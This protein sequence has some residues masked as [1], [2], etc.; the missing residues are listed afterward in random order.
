MSPSDPPQSDKSQQG[1]GTLR[2]E[3]GKD[4]AEA[5]H[6]ARKKENQGAE[7]P[8]LPAAFAPPKTSD[9][10]PPK[11]ASDRAAPKP[12]APTLPAVAPPVPDPQRKPPESPVVLLPTSQPRRNR[13]APIVSVVAMAV[14]LALAAGW[15]FSH[16]VGRSPAGERPQQDVAR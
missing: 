2:S 5:I 7:T 13:T 15:F 1:L 11:K 14:I 12:P 6:E 10:P 9:R 8:A 3:V 4:V 16:H